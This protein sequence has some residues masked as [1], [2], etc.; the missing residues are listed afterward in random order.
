[1]KRRR[2]LTRSA[3][4]AT[5]A[6]MPS[7]AQQSGGFQPAQ[8]IRPLIQELTKGAAIEEGGIEVTLPALAENGN[9][10]PMQ[11]KVDHPM[12]AGDYVAAIHVI[13]ERNP[14]PHVASF[15]LNPESGR[16]EVRTR[17][18]LAG[19]QKV[20]VLAGMSNGGFRMTRTEVV[21]TSAACL[22]ESM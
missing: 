8:D 5:A 17:I 3:L 2:F 18:R 1:M 21:V 12:N 9:S 15:H 10:V 6:A 19:T 20:T 22:D 14:R 7:L 11:V 13:A 4:V 16:A